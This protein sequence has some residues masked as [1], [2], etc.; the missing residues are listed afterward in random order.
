MSI[1]LSLI[2]IKFETLMPPIVRTA[3]YVQQVLITLAICFQI[4]NSR[5]RWR[6]NF[7]RLAQHRRRTDFYRNLRASL[8][9]TFKEAL[10][11]QYTSP[12]YPVYHWDTLHVL[13]HYW[14]TQHCSV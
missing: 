5:T 10:S 3:F 14:Y 12:L 8:D 2:P 7:K 11:V 6:S 9:S 13:T 4:T 1:I